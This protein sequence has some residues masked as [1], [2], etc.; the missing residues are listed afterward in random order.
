MTKKQLERDVTISEDAA[1][2]AKAKEDMSH[3][4]G[5]YKKYYSLIFRFIRKRITNQ[6]QANDI[7]SQVFLK[8]M[9]KLGDYKHQGFPF[10]SWLYRIALSEMGN[11]FR[12][13]STE[14]AL[15][16]DY[17]LSEELFSEIGT[18]AENSDAL[19]LG[20]AMNALSEEHLNMLEMRYFEK[21][22]LKEIAQIMN[23]SES[24]AKVK[25]HRIINKL[26]K[27]LQT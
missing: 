21:I 23:I 22:K 14:R 24:N 6:E 8:A 13:E 19:E 26:R 10:S 2:V 5:L 27:L 3:F 9:L 1:M 18:S 25:M 16:V 7:T 20:R 12:S 17:K 11:L 4:E 15:R